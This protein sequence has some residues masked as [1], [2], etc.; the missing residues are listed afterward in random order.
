MRTVFVTGATGAIGSVLARCLLDEP[1]TRVRLLLRAQSP[2]H[3]SE[4]LEQLYRFWEIDP[5][6]RQISDRV[7][8]LAGDVT[9]PRFG[10]DER[11]FERVSADT[12]HL[13]HSAGNV[14]L[15]RPIEEA[16]ASAVD[17]AR[18]AVSLAR[19]CM[20]RGVF[21]K[22][23]FV[24]T[25]GVSGHM[26]GVVPER[27]FVE[28]RTF[29]NSYEAAKAEAETFLFAEMEQG[30][31][32]TIH[33]PSMVV[34]DSRTGRIIQFQVF[35]YLCEFLSG[36]RTAGIVPDAKDIRLDIIPVDYVARAMQAASL[37]PDAAGRVFHLCAG[38]AQA[39]QVM[40]LARRVRDFFASHGR[41]TPPLR[42][43]PARLMRTLLPVASLI[44]PGKARRTLQSLPYFLAYLDAPQTFG[45]AL[46]EEFFASAGVKAPAVDSY[47]DAVL[48][49]YIS[50]N[51]RRND[52]SEARSVRGVA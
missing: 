52:T 43:V 20:R 26:P 41:H 6:D 48:T 11:S 50:R 18:H 8:A 15:N 16:R 49:Y 17:S 22:L 21:Q 32:A 19:E 3:L 44:V 4:R 14:K 31:P 36:R 47:L 9:Q 25:V 45:N 51:D 30:L 28:A 46:S 42:P 39:P 35:Y 2:A 24:S 12:T 38:P 10:L 1:D 33:R 7:E 29:R 23:D 40:H 5:K 34:G 37:R 13:I 27:P